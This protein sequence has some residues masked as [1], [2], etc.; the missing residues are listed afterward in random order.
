MN[1]NLSAF[2]AAGPAGAPGAAAAAES[3][4]GLAGLR[5]G[6]VVR[7]EVLAPPADSA[8][9]TA[10]I[11]QAVAQGAA[12]ATRQTLLRLG[13]QVLAAQV[14]GGPLRSGTTVELQY[15]GQQ[16]GVA[17]FQTVPTPN[18]TR[19]ATQADLSAL[20]RLAA[21]LQALRGDGGA[22][23]GAEATAAGESAPVWTQPGQPSEVAARALA[24]ALRSSGLFYESHLG[25]WAQGAHPLAELL[26]EPQGQLS[27]RLLAAAQSQPDTI[28]TSAAGAAGRD[29]KAADSRSTPPPAGSDARA[30][31]ASAPPLETAAPRHAAAAVYAGIQH[32]AQPAG[33]DPAALAAQLP[34]S[35]RGIVQ[36][37]LQTLMQGQVFW[38]GPIWPGQTARWTLWADPE[39]SGDDPREPLSPRGWHA[40]LELDLP[41]LGPVRAAMTLRGNRLDLSLRAAETGRPLLDAALPA[42]QRALHAVGVQLGAVQWPAS[43]EGV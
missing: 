34:E 26:T 10:R 19:P 20:A 36:Q 12:L 2:G 39:A 14:S 17:Q 23:A 32:S 7:A 5:I 13:D 15:L 11:A 43:S 35:L 21:Q 38:Q 4:S 41:R 31:A 27:P 33:G 6:A 8:V 16:R 42:L 1:I 40:T 9:S 18:A 30:A 25:A 29:A 3:P 28:Q 22:A 37:Q 24:Q